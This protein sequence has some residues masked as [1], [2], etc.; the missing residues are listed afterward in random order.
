MHLIYLKEVKDK[1]L[2]CD[3]IY[4]KF[5]N[6]SYHVQSPGFY[7]QHQIKVQTQRKVIS[8]DRSDNSSFFCERLWVGKGMKISELLLYSR[9]LEVTLYNLTVANIACEY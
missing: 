9:E 7:P 5:K 6:V 2:L 3:S 8:D 4:L 1:N